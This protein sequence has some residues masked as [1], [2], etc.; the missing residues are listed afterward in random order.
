LIKICNSPDGNI[1]VIIHL[2]QQVG[3][4]SQILSET[5]NTGMSAEWWRSCNR[6]LLPL[7]KLIT[8]VVV[9]HG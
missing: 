5:K 1:L 3:I 7:L 4:I 2:R 9:Q 8:S 6:L